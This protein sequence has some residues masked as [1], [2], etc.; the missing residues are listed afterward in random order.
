MLQPSGRPCVLGHRRPGD[1]GSGGF[2]G[3]GPWWRRRGSSLSPRR[4]PR[5]PAPAGAIAPR[6][7]TRFRTW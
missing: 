3:G 2:R 1:R 7:G 4:R 5:C 6:M